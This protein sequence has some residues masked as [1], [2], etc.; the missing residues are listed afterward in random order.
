MTNPKTP[1][2]RAGSSRSKTA[3]ATSTSDSPPSTNPPPP[4]PPDNNKVV[5]EQLVAL[6]KSISDLVQQNTAAG[7]GET[8]PLSPEEI[9]AV[10]AY[11]FLG[12][13]L[14][15]RAP[16]V[17]QLRT[18]GVSR[19]FGT[20]TFTELNGA[21]VAKIRA[22]NNTTR[23]L[24]GLQNG[25][26]VTID[27]GANAIADAQRIDSIVIFNSPGGVPVAIGPCL[28]PISGGIVD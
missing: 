23:V 12:Q 26:A 5:L 22:G 13:V 28:G 9:R 20:L 6:T 15:R 25:Q 7:D 27:Q 1:E 14:G 24:E 10:F 4:T 18:V 17:F 21:T 2:S 11:D 19:D 8:R 3:A 16:R